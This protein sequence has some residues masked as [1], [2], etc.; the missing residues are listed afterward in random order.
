M[1]DH[2]SSAPNSLPSTPPALAA[3][4]DG[5]V[6]PL[7]PS[8]SSRRRRLP[9]LGIASLSLGSCDSHSL[10]D[11]IAAAAKHGFTSIELFDLDWQHFRD[12]HARDH[13]FGLPCTEGDEATLSAAHALAALCRHHGVAVSCWQPLRNFEGF[14]DAEDERAARAHAKGILDVLPILGTDLLLCCTTSTPAPKT[15]PSLAKA[16]DDLRWLA[17][18]AATYSPPIRIMY[19][20]LSFGAHRQSWQQAWEVVETA[21]RAN[22][23]LC[24]DSFNTLAL[25]W[26][27][28]YA[29]DGR[30]GPDVDA[31]LE[32]NMDELVR[33]VPGDK[34]FL[35][36]VADGRFMSPPLTPPTDPSIPRIRP[37]SR[38]HRLFP[39]ERSLGAYL[40]VDRFSDAVVATGY[41]G[42]WSLEVFNDSLADEGAE[43]PEEHAQRGMV[44][45]KRAAQEAYERAGYKVEVFPRPD[46]HGLP[47]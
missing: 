11:K 13:G 8:P 19:E 7:G 12:A 40:P 26:A 35:Y 46:Q 25:E 45:L 44:G 47:L 32:R 29:E 4:D 33:R 5:L 23:G 20:G 10:A 41:E 31:K 3:H 30:L 18:L 36:Q 24:L 1:S 42:P 22:L 15:T 2:S 21:D 17:D 34:I 43:V 9:A 39:L 14:V 6:T 28:P 16:V 37:W 38:S 27:D